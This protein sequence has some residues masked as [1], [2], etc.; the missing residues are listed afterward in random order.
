[1]PEPNEQDLTPGQEAPV[2]SDSIAFGVS[3]AAGRLS[4][5]MDA[6]DATL[7]TRQLAEVMIRRI[8]SDDGPLRED[9][10]EVD[11]SSVAKWMQDT[12]MGSEAANQLA[13]RLVSDLERALEGATDADAAT[14]SVRAGLA[15]APT[16]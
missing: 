2:R 7:L 6:S 1:M 5:F 9:Q 4:D 13:G 16:T 8:S 12:G 11:V 3:Q 15:E 14:E 10:H